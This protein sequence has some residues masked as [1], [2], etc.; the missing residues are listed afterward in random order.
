MAAPTPRKQ[1]WLEKQAVS[2]RWFKN[3]RTR[4]IRLWADRI[5][6]H[7]EAGAPAAGELLFEA[8]TRVARNDK[9]GE[10]RLSIACADRVLVLQGSSQVVSVATPPALPQ[11]T[12]GGSRVR[13]QMP[14]ARRSTS[15][16]R[17]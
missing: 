11:C 5:C 1:G 10:S 14:S 2:A 3:W 6:W 8:C 13:R 12:C 16:R 17:L 9:E 15:G 7:R 4:D